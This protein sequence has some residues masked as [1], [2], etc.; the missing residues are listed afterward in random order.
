MGMKYFGILN[1]KAEAALAATGVL[2]NR[3]NATVAIECWLF[4]KVQ[5]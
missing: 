2:T 4:E 3:E 1:G 5:N